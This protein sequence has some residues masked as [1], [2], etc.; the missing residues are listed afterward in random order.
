[1]DHLY[2]SPHLDDAI[3]SCGGA[4]CGQ[5][6]RG[7]RVVVLTIFAGDP[8]A[9]S[10]SSF[11]RELHNRWGEERSPVAARRAE[12]RRACAILGAQPV[13]LDFLDC[14]YRVDGRGVALYPDKAAIFGKVH[15]LDQP[16]R[17]RLRLALG[18]RLVPSARVYCPLGIGGH[19]DHLLVRSAAERLAEGLWLYPD[20]PYAARAEEFLITTPHEEARE[21]LISVSENQRRRWERAAEAY[22]SQ[23]SSFWES[24]TGLREDIRTYM[25]RNGGGIP[26]SEYAPRPGDGGA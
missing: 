4:I 19:V 1:M 22:A 23:I 25:K 8:P 18:A 20:M 5:V 10:L 26:M 7:E 13:H 17:E 11:A 15:P 12:D 14:V 16:L 6:A 2:L 3:W 9:G 24:P 21:H